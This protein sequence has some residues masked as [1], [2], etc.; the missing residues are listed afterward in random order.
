MR[1]FQF[2]STFDPFP[3][4]HQLQ[5]HPELWD[6]NRLRTTHPQSPHQQVSDIW[7]RFNDLAEY[8]KTADAAKVV[9]EHESVWYPAA[10]QL[11]TIK[12]II[13]GLMSKVSGVRLG[14]VLITKLAPGKT[15]DAHEDGGSHAAYYERYHC[16]LQGLPGSLFRC[17]TEEICMSTG[18]IWWFDNSVQHEVRNNSA[19]DRIHLIVDIKS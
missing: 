9:D 17:G 19:D 12:P 16:V 13:F 14:R 6:Q 4:V 5:Q 18:Q 2:V 1:N 7:I 3:L 11:W 15:I 8:E 10:G